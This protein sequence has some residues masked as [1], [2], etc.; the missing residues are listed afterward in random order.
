MKHVIFDVGNVLLQWDPQSVIEE[1]LPSNQ[2]AEKA[3]ALSFENDLWNQFDAGA[4]TEQE[5]LNI[6]QQKLNIP[7]EIVQY[8]Y[9]KSM[10]SLTP[11]PGSL[12]L[13]EELNQNNVALYCITNM[14]LP[15]WDHLSAQYA[16]WPIFKHIV[17]SAK[18][19]LI[20]PNPD[21]Y[22]H[23]LEEHHLLPNDS[24]FIDDRAENIASAEKIGIHGIQFTDAKD[25]RAQLVKLQ[26]LS[27]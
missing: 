11:I 23:L 5:V 8:L 13:L 21:I 1:V 6:V 10:Q 16:F 3:L 15:F 25:C 4:L 27:D 17:V 24:V 19:K 9:E 12:E 7:I 14:S 22:W 2:M 26:L 20:K 18:V